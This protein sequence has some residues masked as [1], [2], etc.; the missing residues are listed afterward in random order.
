MNS[1]LGLSAAAYGF[2]AG[3]FFIGYGL[4]ELPS[5]LVRARGGARRWIARIAVTWGILACATA[6]VRGAHGFYLLRFLLGTAE[7][8][9]FPGIIYFLSQCQFPSEFARAPFPASCSAFR[10]PASSVVR[11]AACSSRSMGVWGSP[12]GGGSFSSKVFPRWRSV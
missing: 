12:D 7:A 11:S 3:V 2:G 5:N 4:F 10:S 9:C 6:F 1:S 8:G